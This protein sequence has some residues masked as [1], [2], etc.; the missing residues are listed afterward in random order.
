MTVAR[1]LRS[2]PSPSRSG[3]RIPRGRSSWDE[4]TSCS[5]SRGRGGPLSPDGGRPCSSSERPGPGSPGWSLRP[6]CGS[7]SMVPRSS[8]A[9]A[10]RMRR[11]HT[12]RSVRRWA[13]SW[14]TS[15]GNATGPEL[16]AVRD[17]LAAP[18]CG[19]RDPPPGEALARALLRPSKPW[20]RVLRR[21]SAE[22]PV[23]LV[24]EDLHWA[25]P[26]TMDLLG[27]IVRRAPD[28]RTCVVLITSRNTRPD[29]SDALRGTLTELYRQPGVSTARAQRSDHRG[30]RS[31]GG[32]RGGHR[33]CP[34]P[35]DG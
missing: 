27:W 16:D 15:A 8:S 24:V 30:H 34:G 1:R 10:C 31:H 3:G 5:S 22:R 18:P 14:R 35:G 6:A 32:G 23:V 19:A 11:S 7:P 33:P 29:L 4:P 17:L 2:P 12:S 25:T 28:W 13:V 26:S 20:S 21:A 9:A